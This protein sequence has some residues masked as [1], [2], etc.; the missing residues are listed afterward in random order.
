M[1]LLSS[2]RAACSLPTWTVPPSLMLKP[3]DA[4]GKCPGELATAPSCCPQPSFLPTYATTCPSLAK[5]DITFGKT[6]SSGGNS[7]G[8]RQK[9]GEFSSPPN[10][11]S[12]TGLSSGKLHSTVVFFSPVQ[13]GTEELGVLERRETCDWL[14]ALP[15]PSDN[16]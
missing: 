8:I 15:R 10:K 3:K 2:C 9:W 6:G 13:V 12:K 16:R 5:E 7:S 4:G 1:S 11:G 14:S